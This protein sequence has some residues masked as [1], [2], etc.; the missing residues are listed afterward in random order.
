MRCGAGP[1]VL[2]SDLGS[3]GCGSTESRCLLNVRAPPGSHLPPE[4]PSLAAEARAAFGHG[5]GAVRSDVL[6]WTR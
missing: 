1:D 5:V 3:A 2:R 4:R 6:W